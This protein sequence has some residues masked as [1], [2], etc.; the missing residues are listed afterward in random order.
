[1]T[2]HDKINTMRYILWLIIIAFFIFV[3]WIVFL[4]PET[5]ELEVQNPVWEEVEPPANYQDL[6]GTL[7]GKDVKG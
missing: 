7:E 6:E 1:L 4:R 2:E 3:V 5:Y